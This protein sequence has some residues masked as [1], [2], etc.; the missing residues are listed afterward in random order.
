MIT[1][2]FA[3]AAELD[4]QQ[5][6]LPPVGVPAW[7]SWTGVYVGTHVGAGWATTQWSN[8]GSFSSPGPWR[9]L[10]NSSSFLGG[11]QIGANWQSGRFVIG[12]EAGASALDGSCS[13]IEVGCGSKTIGAVTGRIGATVDHTLFY[14]KGG[15]AGMQ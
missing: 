7:L 5:N 10:G 13:G 15:A 9:S 11:G 2:G 3:Q 6:T 12:I 14:P 1:A 8:F 4:Q